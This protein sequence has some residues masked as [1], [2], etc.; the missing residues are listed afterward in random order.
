MD[1]KDGP[2]RDLERRAFNRCLSI[3]MDRLPEVGNHNY[4]EKS[5]ISRL[6]VLVGESK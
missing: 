3:S 6:E 2:E 4:R 5:S 1:R